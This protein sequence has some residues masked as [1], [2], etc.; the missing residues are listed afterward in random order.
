MVK[1][2]PLKGW[3]ESAYPLAKGV[4]DRYTPALPVSDRREIA[5]T[6]TMLRLVLPPPII[7]VNDKTG[8]QT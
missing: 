2:H 1:C 4:T 7:A 8:G 6:T 5:G 3:G